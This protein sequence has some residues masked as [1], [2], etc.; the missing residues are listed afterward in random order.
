MNFAHASFLL[1]GVW[2][3]ALTSSHVGFAAAMALGL[4]AAGALGLLVERPL[5]SRIDGRRHD[6]LA[7]LTIGVNVVLT[8]ELS[9]RIGEKVLPFGA[10]RDGHVIHLGGVVLPLSVI[11]TIIT[12]PVLITGLAAVLRHTGRGPAMRASIEDRGRTP[13]VRACSWPRGAVTATRPA[14]APGLLRSR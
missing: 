2:G 6:P 1:F 12:V 9:W 10:P 7:I 5:L 14:P 4:V 11:V 13:P 8:A 3:V